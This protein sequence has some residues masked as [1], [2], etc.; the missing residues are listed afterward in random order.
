MSHSSF[1]TEVL[2]YLICLLLS[3]DSPFPDKNSTVF[4]R[5]HGDARVPRQECNDVLCRSSSDLSTLLSENKEDRQRSCDRLVKREGSHA[6]LG[7]SR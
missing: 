6:G 7:I 1:F 4:L 3:L 5:T 2:S